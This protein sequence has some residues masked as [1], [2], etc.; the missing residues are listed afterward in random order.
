MFLQDK[1]LVSLV[2]TGGR[3]PYPFKRP[4]I[5]LAKRATGRLSAKPKISA[6]IAVPRRPIRRIGFRP[7]LSLSLPHMTPVE[8]SASVKAEVTMPA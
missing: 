8:N 3:K 5:A 2:D 6:L 1:P 7:N 4:P